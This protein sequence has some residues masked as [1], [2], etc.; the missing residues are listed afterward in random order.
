M[1]IL[2]LIKNNSKI[3]KFLIVWSISTL[4]D[5]F[6]L[7]IFVDI[8]KITLFIAVIFSFLIAVI[9]W[10][11]W[12]KLWT[13]KNKSIKY[14]R[15]FTKFLFV[16]TFGLLLTLSFMYFFTIILWIYYILSKL[17]TSIIVVIWNFL[18]N[19]YWTFKIKEDKNKE[20]DNFELLYSIIIPSYNEE[21]RL[22]DT[23]KKV[24]TFFKKT[25]Y[26]YEILV[27]DDWSYDNTISTIEKLHIL[28]L[29]ILKNSKNK[30]KGFS[31]KKWVLNANWKYIL[32]IDADN[33]TP[34]EELINLEK[35]IEDF[36]IVI[37]SRYCNNAK[38]KIKQWILRQK[39][40]R[41]WNKI[42]Q[43][44]LLD[45]INDTQCWFKLFKHNIAKRLFSLQKINWFWFDMEI[46][47][48]WKSIWYSIKE[49]PVKWYNSD[50]SRV[51][52]IRDSLK[53]LMELLFIKI[54]YWFDWYK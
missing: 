4:I 15:Q 46:L 36:D 23:L 33:S 39:I 26:T 32:F 11:T 44:F 51:R 1:V 12:N 49:V 22:P 20:K 18:W 53:T 52:P 47:L 54:N 3:I 27:I 45:W 19:K 24:E 25:K 6:F 37:W 35:Y 10:F 13:F 21:N 5:V 48:A 42:I 14:K 41:I 8:F 29:K 7:Y 40:W 31:V 2:K 30:W 38:V 9:N 28:N 43:L 50:F 17:L 16:S 34:I